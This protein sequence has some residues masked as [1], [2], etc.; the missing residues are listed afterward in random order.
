MNTIRYIMQKEFRQIFRNR[1]LLPMIIGVPLVQMLIL[2]YAATFDLKRIDM[3]VV[4]NDHS[5][6]SRQ[7]TAKFE[8][9]PFFHIKAC[10]LTS[11]TREACLMTGEDDVVMV[12]PDGFERKLIR[13]NYSQL[14]LLINAIDGNSAQLIFSYASQIIGDF[15]QKIILHQAEI[16]GVTPPVRVNITEKYWFNSVLEY[17]WYMAPGILAVLVTIIGMFMSGMNLVREKETGTIEQLNVTPVKKHQFIIGKLVPFWILALIDMAFGL[18]IA[19]LVFDLPVEGSLL[20]LFGFAGVYLI[21]VLGL[22]LFISTV[23]DTQQQVMFVSSFF[24]M[25]FILMG[26]IFTPVES[27]PHWAQIADRLNPIYYF[28]RIMRNVILKGSGFLDLIE[29][30]VSLVILGILFLSL[31]IRR[32]RKTAH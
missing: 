30:F 6:T 14:Q 25:I 4:D 10:A 26:G 11:E 21:S 15:N 27:M 31:A 16:P 32:Y 24:M 23:A 13:E 2:V 19:W 3:V 7:L 5:E 12:M 9:I 22:G 8:G 18:L 1:T 20:L 17:K 28:M 29:E